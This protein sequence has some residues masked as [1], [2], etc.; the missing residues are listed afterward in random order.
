[1]SI[2]SIIQL[3]ATATREVTNDV[4]KINL[5][6]NASGT[7][8]AQVQE[9]L[10]ASVNEALK[11]I[12][13]SAKDEE[14]IVTTE[15][16][17]ITPRYDAKGAKINGYIGSAV[18][19]IK[20]TD[21]ATISTLAS[22]VKTMVVSGS[23]NSVSRKLRESLEA[24]LTAEAIATFRTKAETAAAGFGFKGFQIVNVNINAQDRGYYGGGGVKM[25]ATASLAA[26]SA[27]MEVET[28]RSS[29]TV[30]VQGS[31]TPLASRGTRSSGPK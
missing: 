1:M 15:S 6:A 11:L 22:K 27:P 17:N 8:A 4:L 19:S 26:A 18:V 2:D 29:I 20:G 10:R 31:V 23:E 24:E 30:S 25:M 21:S 12:R 28:G 3:N 14:V 13:P 5:V 16:F 9:D 7:E